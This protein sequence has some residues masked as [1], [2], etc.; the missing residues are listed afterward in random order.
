MYGQPQHNIVLIFK[1]AA[2]YACCAEQCIHAVC[3]LIFIQRAQTVFLIESTN[4]RSL[5]HSIIAF[6][7]RPL[8]VVPNRFLFFY[9]RS[10]SGVPCHQVVY[11]HLTLSC[12][13]WQVTLGQG[14]FYLQQ[15]QVLFF[16]PDHWFLKI[17]KR[18][19]ECPRMIKINNGLP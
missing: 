6:C 12:F 4:Q 16:R 1:T 8:T 14:V 5:C 2:L 17:L 9:G 13:T 3:T 11:I 10:T 15:Y 19:L 7:P 18:S